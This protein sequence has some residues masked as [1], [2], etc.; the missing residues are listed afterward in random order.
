MARHVAWYG[1][2]LALLPAVGLC[3]VDSAISC[4]REASVLECQEGIGTTPTAYLDLQVYDLL[5]QQSVFV[6]TPALVQ[7]WLA[8]QDTLHELY[9]LT[10]A[11]VH[12]C[13]STDGE[14]SY[15]LLSDA[16]STASSEIISC[17]VL[18]VVL[19]D[20]I[21][22]GRDRELAD[23]LLQR[24]RSVAY[25]QLELLHHDYLQLRHD[26]NY[27]YYENA[28]SAGF[29]QRFDRLLDKCIAS[30]YIRLATKVASS[31]GAF[32]SYTPETLEQSIEAYQQC[33][34][35]A[36]KASPR[37]SKEYAFVANS[38]I[39]RCLL[40]LGRYEEALGALESI[41]TTA[42]KWH[43]PQNK[44]YY[45]D[46]LAVCYERLDQPGKALL[47]YRKSAH[48]T[49][50]AK[51]E[52]LASQVREIKEKYQNQELTSSLQQREFELRTRSRLLALVASLLLISVL[53][54]FL[55]RKVTR[56]RRHALEQS[57]LLEQAE[58]KNR[59]LEALHHERTRIAGEM[60][61]DLGGG[62]TTIK[63]LSNKLT[64]KLDDDRLRRDV[65]KIATNA[66][67]L[68]NNMSEII[69][70]MNGGMDTVEN[71][72]AYCR[73]YA[74]EY[75]EDYEV[76][77]EFS[78]EGVDGSQ[79]MTGEVRRNVFLVIK[80]VLHNTIKHAGASTISM[81]FEQA[82]PDGPLRITYADDGV[83]LPA[84]VRVNGHGLRS[85]RTRIESI[86]GNIDIKGAAGV[87]ITMEVS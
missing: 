71:L 79:P 60:H 21:N 24:Y 61:D 87:I 32:L 34:A 39:A 17:E 57:L 82:S 47:Y 28:S 46:W 31:Y 11:M 7:R 23:E 81:D 75:L 66:T 10:T 18:K 83:G 36:Q 45:Y 26:L 76:D 63:Y 72:V 53:A 69:W 68:V 48:Y 14:Q 38:N 52:E 3:Q 27:Y 74:R 1:F 44:S 77:L 15:V 5:R 65:D 29:S 62:L 30:G 59:Q 9:P 80:E 58:S 64:R 12:R 25:D 84:E 20:V 70:A 78:A 51:V 50:I 2:L 85:M 67:T 55:F 49:E 6:D 35:L 16:L 73:R 43:N 19:D 42:S 8:S 33:L 37:F 54:L 86:G 13:L 41:D 22:A 4:L 56:Q 40:D